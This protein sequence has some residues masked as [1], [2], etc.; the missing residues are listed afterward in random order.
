SQHRRNDYSPARGSGRKG[1][2]LMEVPNPPADVQ[3]NL[4][5]LERSLR[6]P[7][8]LFSAVMSLLTGAATIAAMFP[9]F[10]VLYMLLQ[11]G[12]AD[13]NLD[14]LTQL[15]PPAMMPGGGVGNAI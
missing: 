1:L 9:L 14:T 5:E 10:S 13:L 8:V 15:P 4:P 7:R 3:V 11:K 2:A 6:K 12:A